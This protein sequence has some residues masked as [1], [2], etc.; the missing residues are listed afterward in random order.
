MD[1]LNCLPNNLL[2]S[3]CVVHLLAI[4]K[5]DNMNIQVFVSSLFF[6]VLDIYL[7]AELLSHMV[8]L[9]LI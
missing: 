8:I 7:G 4:V 6:I 5:S 9:C 3:I 2:M 1:I